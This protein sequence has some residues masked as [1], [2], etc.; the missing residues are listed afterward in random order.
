MKKLILFGIILSLSASLKANIISV[1][2]YGAIPNDGLDDKTA[3]NAAIQASASGDTI[4]FPTGTYNLNGI[5]ING[6]KMMLYAKTNLVIDGQG[7]TLACT[8]WSIVFGCYSS[9]NIKVMNFSTNWDND[10]PFTGGTVTAKGGSYIDVRIRGNQP[11]RTGVTVGAIMRYDSI[12]MH[13]SVN[14]Y[15]IYQTNGT[16]TTNP[17]LGILRVPVLAGSLPLISVGDNI[18]VRFQVYGGDFFNTIISSNISLQNLTVNS[19][20]GMALYSASITNLTIDNFNVLRKPGYW[21]STCADAMHFQSDRGAINVTNS[22]LEGMGDDGL[23]IHSS[24]M[25]ITGIGANTLTVIDPYSG[26]IT[27]VNTDPLPGDS[28]EIYN[29]ST[30]AIVAKIFVQSVTRNTSDITITATATI[31]GTVAVN[32]FT[33]NA[34]QLPAASITNTI[35]RNSRARGILIQDRNVTV[36]NCSLINNSLPGILVET[37]ANSFFESIIPNNV[38]IQNCTFNNNNY[39]NW[40]YPGQLT[41]RAINGLGAAAPAGLVQK[42]K[43]WDNNF[44]GSYN[45]T[46]NRTAIGLSSSDSIYIRGNTFDAN[47]FNQNIY[48]ANT[49]YNVYINTAN[50]CTV[51]TPN[52][53]AVNLPATILAE[54]VDNGGQMVAYFERTIPSPNPSPSSS[55]LQVAACGGSCSGFFVNN[56]EKNEWLQYSVHLNQLSIYKT[57]FRCGSTSVGGAS[58]HLERD[59]VNLTGTLSVAQTGANFANVNSS[60]FNLPQGTYPLRLVVESGTLTLDTMQF[61]LISLLAVDLVS[62]NVTLVHDDAHLLWKVSETNGCNEYSVLRSFDGINFQPVGRVNCQGNSGILNYYFT[63]S[64]IANIAGNQNLVYYRLQR[65]DLNGIQKMLGDAVLRLGKMDNARL[66]VYPNPAINGKAIL[67]LKMPAPAIDVIRIFNT[68]GQPV[69]NKEIMVVTGENTL[70]LDLQTLTKG[71][72]FISLSNADGRII[73]QTQKLIVQ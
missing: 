11:L 42:I 69:W 6:V 41:I 10:L 31:P 63:D 59:H 68:Y 9:N 23:N 67:H 52:G 13:P 36:S 21:L 55:L 50:P 17:S 64:N 39:W 20:P 25:K 44:I 38:T 18:V 26:G 4:I 2:A 45:S 15:D 27:N 62:L 40:G 7:S 51:S 72:Y 32:Q 16:T 46:D 71:I 60:N 5:Y 43:I 8:G 22:T 65:T 61:T 1:A 53:S 33:A 47:Y 12:N 35:V 58:F 37:T 34:S 29:S 19:E 24:Y 14:G 49:G 66:I 48:L 3:I 56:I 57:L 70:P 54:N 30:L 28:L 73:D